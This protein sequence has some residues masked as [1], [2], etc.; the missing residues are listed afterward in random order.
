MSSGRLKSAHHTQ[1]V[2]RQGSD[3]K[4]LNKSLPSEYEVAGEE[5]ERGNYMYKDKNI[6]ND[7]TTKYEMN[8]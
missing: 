6:Y 1:D 3:T 5:K 7:I 2:G 4:T 8:L